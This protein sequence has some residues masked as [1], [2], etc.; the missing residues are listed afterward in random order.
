VRGN[1]I[2][3]PEG[4]ALDVTGSGQMLVESN[5]LTAHGNNSALILILSLLVQN[6]NAALAFFASPGVQAQLQALRAQIV[7]SCVAIVNTGVNPNVLV[8]LGGATA[9]NGNTA[10]PSTGA[11]GNN[12]LRQPDRVI[13]Q[14][15]PQG[16]VMFNDNQVTFDTF[17]SAATIALCSVAIL[18]LDD[19][20][21][22]DN[23]CM[24]DRLFDFVP[25]NAF[26]FG[27]VSARVQ[28]NRF[29]EIT[30]FDL[31]TED[32]ADGA[33]VPL[34]ALTFGLLN[35][36]ELNQGTHCFLRLGPKQ[37]QIRPNPG[38]DGEL[39]LDTNRHLILDQN[40]EDYFEISVD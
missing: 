2:V 33:F 39:V 40:C 18:S 26:V 38:N 21:M 14:I 23:Q 37:P 32:V 31:L 15:P 7:G 35:A 3:S 1:S 34:S 28:G 17:N 30:N 4:R 36:T 22:Q 8:A 9:A 29:R 20:A 12:Q 19:V 6:D 13:D 27:F 25:I 5:A 10:A 24:V 11:A 16:P